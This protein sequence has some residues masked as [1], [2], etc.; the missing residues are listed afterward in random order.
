[1]PNWTTNMIVIS[2]KQSVREHIKEE[3]DGHR[4]ME[5]LKD[6]PLYVVQWLLQE[7]LPD[8]DDTDYT[9]KELLDYDPRGSFEDNLNDMVFRHDAICALS[10]IIS[11]L[12]LLPNKDTLEGYPPPSLTAWTGDTEYARRRM[13]IPGIDQQHESEHEFDPSTPRI[14][15][16]SV[17]DFNKIIPMPDDIF[18]GNLGAE[19][20]EKYG[21]KNWYD[22]SCDNWGTKWPACDAEITEETDTEIHYRFLTAWDAP[23]PIVDALRKKM[24]EDFGATVEWECVHEDGAEEETL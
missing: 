13:S 12:Y 4:T 18:R 23:R 7:Y 9:P 10:T 17:F 16:K 1:M 3:L 8:E 14:A 11:R 21:N 19:E 15:A 20:R 24:S 2:C 22:W 5:L 6:M